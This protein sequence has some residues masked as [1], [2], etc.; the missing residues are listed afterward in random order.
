MVPPDKPSGACMKL[1]SLLINLD[2]QA[3]R[4]L[5]VE[6]IAVWGWDEFATDYF[7]IGFVFK[8]TMDNITVVGQQ[9]PVGI[10]LVQAHPVPTNTSVCSIGQGGSLP[11]A[12]PTYF[13]Y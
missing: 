4:I 5:S 12:S 13:I 1:H 9:N 11:Q 6:Q 10:A 7:D 3:P 8:V 2:L